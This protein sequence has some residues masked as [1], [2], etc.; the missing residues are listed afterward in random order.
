[1][2]RGVILVCLGI[3]LA[4]VGCD[5]ITL[6]DNN[7]ETKPEKQVAGRDNEGLK[8]RVDNLDRRT[9]DA[10][11]AIEKRVSD[12][13]QRVQQLERPGL[14]LRVRALEQQRRR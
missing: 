6:V 1:M 8:L 13:A 4:V 9:Q 3:S 10:A 11:T 12:L 7:K 5:R 2:Y 14:E